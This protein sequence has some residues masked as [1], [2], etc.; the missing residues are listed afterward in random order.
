MNSENTPAMHPFPAQ[1]G[2][3]C[4]C[5]GDTLSGICGTCCAPGEPD[6]SA[7]LDEIRRRH[8][9]CPDPGDPEDEYF[10]V[11]PADDAAPDPDPGVCGWDMTEWPC[12]TARLLEAL[13]AMQQER[14]EARADQEVTQRAARILADVVTQ[15]RRVL[16]AARIECLQNGPA[17]G[18]EWVLESNPD[19]WDGKPGTEW[20]GH[21]TAQQWFD[22]V[23]AAVETAAT[24]GEE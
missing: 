10:I 11:D 23:T 22:R 18:M 1:E 19:V 20:D 24:A 17:K 12:D 6:P 5:H 3:P 7:W 13:A 15:N 9:Q 21:E 8:Q 2:C 14:D 4:Q 16:E